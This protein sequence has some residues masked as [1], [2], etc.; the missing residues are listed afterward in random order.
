MDTDNVSCGYCLLK[1]KIWSSY[2][3]VIQSSYLFCTYQNLG[4][5]NES[6]ETFP[7]SLFLLQLSQTEGWKEPAEQCLTGTGV[8]TSTFLQASFNSNVWNKYK[9]TN[10][11]WLQNAIKTQCYLADYNGTSEIHL[12]LKPQATVLLVWDK[13]KMGPTPLSL[14]SWEANKSAESEKSARPKDNKRHSQDYNRVSH[15]SFQT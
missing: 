3:P 9:P 14:Q 4:L 8:S 2:F 1:Q 11:G 15:L 5:V 13:L 10:Q 7:F 12:K 6:R